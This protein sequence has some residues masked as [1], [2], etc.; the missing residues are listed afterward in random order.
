ML[1]ITGDVAH[2]VRMPLTAEELL[3]DVAKDTNTVEIPT[4]QVNAAVV[5]GV[6]QMLRT[7][8]AFQQ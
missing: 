4:N 3:A 7:N 1:F 6:M 8:E 5:E 2:Q